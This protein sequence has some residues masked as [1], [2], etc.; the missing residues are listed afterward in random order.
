MERAA[1]ERRSFFVRGRARDHQLFRKHVSSGEFF[2]QKRHVFSSKWKYLPL[3][4]GKI[5]RAPANSAGF[6]ARWKISAGP[7]LPMWLKIDG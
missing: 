6:R 1:R 7:H 3:P 2:Q 4:A 5:F